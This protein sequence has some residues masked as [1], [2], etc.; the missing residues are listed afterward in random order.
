MK[1]VIIVFAL[2]ISFTSKAQLVQIDYTLNQEQVIQLHKD[3]GYKLISFNT[4]S[5]R[6]T[7][8]YNFEKVEK[9]LNG[10]T[11]ISKNMITFE[12][13]RM[14]SKTIK[15]NEYDWDYFYKQ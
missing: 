13:G 9:L 6:N 7:E 3:N 8:V 5:Y 10:I 15:I 4:L 12:R 2:L 14:I 1:K 11:R